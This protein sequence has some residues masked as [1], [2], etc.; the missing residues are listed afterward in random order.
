MLEWAK[1]LQRAGIPTGIL[2]NMPDAM[3]RGLRA[4]HSWIEDFNHHTWSHS[5]K[6]AKPEPAIYLHAAEGLNTPPANIL[7]I[8]D[9]AENIAAALGVAMRAIRYTTH[10]AFR[11]EMHARGLDHLLKPEAPADS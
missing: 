5:L 4:K 6:L 10:Q 1:R 7:F 11:Q 8:D 2:S 9:K 3:E